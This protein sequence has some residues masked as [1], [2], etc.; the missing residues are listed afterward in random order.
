[1]WAL[2]IHFLKWKFQ[3]LWCLIT[4]YKIKINLFESQ[5]IFERCFHQNFPAMQYLSVTC[6]INCISPMVRPTILQIK[7]PLS[8]C[9]WLPVCSLPVNSYTLR[10]QEVSTKGKIIE[11]E[12]EICQLPDMDMVGKW[13][14]LYGCLCL[15][16]YIYHMCKLNSLRVHDHI[17][18]QVYVANV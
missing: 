14:S 9:N 3:K 17:L 6:N 5:Q 15:Y 16:S 7:T 13:S 11:F 1:M 4:S 18:M 10:C 8:W 12:L 2:T